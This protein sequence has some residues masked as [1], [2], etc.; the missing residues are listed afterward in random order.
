MNSHAKLLLLGLIFFQCSRCDYMGLHLSLELRI[1]IKSPT[2][3]LISREDLLSVLPKNAIVAEIGVA[4]GQFSNSILSL[5][6]PI[7]LYLIDCWEEQS[8]SI[9]PEYRPQPTQD[10]YYE[11]VKQKFGRDSRVEIIKEYSDKAAK[12]FPDN[13]FDW[14]YIDGNHV[15]EAIKADLESWLPKVKD[16]GIIAG[17][18]Y[19]VRK[20]FGIVSAVN[21]FVKKHDFSICYLTMEYQDGVKHPSYAIKVKK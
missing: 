17:H 11:L 9:Y 1:A 14:I 19:V 20:D 8:F 16:G 18:D 5:T 21:E 7:K 10:G 13:Y 15:Y 6:D 3:W 2:P 12:V 4:E